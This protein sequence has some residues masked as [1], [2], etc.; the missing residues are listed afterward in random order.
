MS[1]SLGLCTLSVLYR[2]LPRN[3][4]GPARRQTEEER[5]GKTTLKR[6]RRKVEGVRG[7]K[8]GE[9]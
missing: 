9:E 8:E 4:G 1:T 6:K 3:E 2:N 7:G 5:E